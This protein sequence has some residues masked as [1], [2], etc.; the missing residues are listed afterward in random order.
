M[1]KTILILFAFLLAFCESKSQSTPYTWSFTA[2]KISNNVFEIHCS[3][4]LTDPWHTYSQFTPAGGPV[5]TKFSFQKNPL[6]T[7]DG[8][9]VENGDLK[10]R[11]EKAFGIDVKYFEGNVDFVQKL[12]LKANTKTNC[13]GAV[14]FMV[15]NDTE[16]LPPFTQKFSV[17]LK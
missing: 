14:T 4:T 1:R 5:P 17:A 8:A 15:C 6:Y 12:T 13:S 16:C 7:I 10:T 2:K 11:F 9:V 3:A